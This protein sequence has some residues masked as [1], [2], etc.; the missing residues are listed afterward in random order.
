[1]TFGHGTRRPAE[2]FCT[3]GAGWCRRQGGANAKNTRGMRPMD[4]LLQAVLKRVIRAGT[5]QV[6]TANGTI[7]TVGDCSGAPV[8]LRC[9]THA[10]ERGIIADPELKFGEAYMDG[11]LVV[12][13]GSIADVL[14]MALRQG[15]D[16]RPSHWATPQW[17]VRYLLR[18][19]LQFNPRPRARRN[20]AHHYDPD[21]QL[22][23]LFIDADRQYSC[24]YFQTT[25]Q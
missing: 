13:R 18:R 4:R 20:V 14:A 10:A 1:M 8:A 23:S 9:A 7:F 17:L 15:R 6:T 25:D 24:A 16:G 12:Q 3:D 21:G 5:L 11:S 2:L 19:V 22:H